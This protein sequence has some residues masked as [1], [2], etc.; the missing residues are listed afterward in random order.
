MTN[1]IIYL[2]PDEDITSVINRIRKSDEDGVI[3]AIPRGGTI[4]Q[5]AVNLKLLVRNATT[6]EKSIGLVTNDKITQNL[7]SRLEIKAF[8][9]VSDAETA[10]LDSATIAKPKIE[11]NGG[12][13]DQILVGGLNV[14][15]Y[16]KYSEEDG[17][18]D[19]SPV[20][21]SQDVEVEPHFAKSGVYPV[22]ETGR[23][24]DAED[25]GDDEPVDLP[26]AD[27]VGDPEEEPHFAQ[28]SRGADAEEKIEEK[29]LNQDVAN[30]PLQQTPRKHLKPEGSR[31]MFVIISAI[32]IISVL[33]LSF[34]FIP[35][36][37]ASL[38]LETSD[39]AKT[40]AVIA[41]R[42][43][44]ETDLANLTI[45]AEL[46]SIEKEGTKQSASTGT[47]D[48]GAKAGGT[49]TLYNK[50]GATVTVS[51]TMK[52]VR[53]DKEFI[54]SKS[55]FIP[56][57]TGSFTTDSEGHL[58]PVTTPGTVNVDVTASA[59]GD[60]YNLA[61]G[62]FSVSGKSISDV[63]AENKAAFSGGVTKELK[64]VTAEDIQKASDALKAELSVASETDLR[65]QA[66]QAG[67]KIADVSLS[68]EII[69]TSSDKTAEQE[70]DGFT[71]TMKIKAYII[72][73]K[74]SDLKGLVFDSVKSGLDSNT[75]L[76]NESK[77]TVNYTISSASV[78]DGLIKLA[79]DF[80]G[81]VGQKLDQS[82]IKKEINN[83]ST[84]K[85]QK[86]LEG[87]DGVASSSLKVSPSFWKLTPFLS[88]RI[89][90]IFDYEENSDVPS[91]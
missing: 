9:K 50:L 60:S 15:T 43:K 4:G 31:R 26:N 87:L 76:V 80:Q 85:A 34:L 70:A 28:A 29:I 22:L 25:A 16:Q 84:A 91:N 58:V 37:E 35:F 52:I 78:N 74:E 71:V 11:A 79:V 30:P 86:Y 45:P 8:S 23:G 24:A 1:K 6:L 67:I 33:V 66:E 65:A 55:V 82:K 77:A 38:V 13:E 61:P 47:K 12:Q 19:A 75:M 73:F 46:V 83:I 62:N 36:V 3:L 10:S 68:S 64:Y 89:K 42:D 69:S 44:T 2:E 59:N 20:E 48:V 49:V 7:A 88:S 14:H 21:V 51:T 27:S 63:W 17:E 5:S 18:D 39:S 57:A 81:K 41:D 54:P 90:I 32:A 72:G 40:L 56:A 53:G